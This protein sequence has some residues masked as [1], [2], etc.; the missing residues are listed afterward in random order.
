MANEFGDVF[1]NENLAID[2]SDDGIFTANPDFGSIAIQR[3]SLPIFINICCQMPSMTFV[4]G[5]LQTFGC[6]NQNVNA[7]DCDVI[8]IKPFFLSGSNNLFHGVVILGIDS[9]N[10]AADEAVIITLLAKAVVVDIVATVTRAHID[11]TIFGLRHAAD[12]KVRFA[13]LMPSD[14][15]VVGLK[16]A[17]AFRADIDNIGLVVIHDCHSLTAH[18]VGTHV[19]PIQRIVGSVLHSGSL[20]GLE[21][22]GRVNQARVL[23]GAKATHEALRIHCG[24]CARHI[25]TAVVSDSELAKNQNCHQER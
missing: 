19:N 1:A 23:I 16:D 15:V 22:V 4:I 9:P 10:A 25:V 20:H 8:D 21:H 7:N 18:I 12:H 6:S 14:T 3:L 17:T 5:I 2:R 11:D 13:H 24:L